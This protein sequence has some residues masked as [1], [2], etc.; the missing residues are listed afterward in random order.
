MS[1]AKLLHHMV[2]G[3][4]NSKMCTLPRLAVLPGAS[5]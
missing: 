1:K 3:G 2:S 5:C 4:F